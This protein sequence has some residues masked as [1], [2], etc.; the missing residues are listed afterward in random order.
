M[1]S[2]LLIAWV[3]ASRRLGDPLLDTVIE[4]QTDVVDGVRSKDLRIN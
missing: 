4:W 3:C 1:S 2:N